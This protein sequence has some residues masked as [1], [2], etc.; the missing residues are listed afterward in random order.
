MLVLKVTTASIQVSTASTQL[1]LLVYKH[2][3]RSCSQIYRITANDLISASGDY[4]S[5]FFLT[6]DP[7]YTTLGL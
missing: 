5:L 4:P 1:I 2:D 3:N 6:G 7:Q